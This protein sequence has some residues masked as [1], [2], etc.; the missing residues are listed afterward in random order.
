MWFGVW[1]IDCYYLEFFSVVFQY[2]GYGIRVLLTWFPIYLL[3]Y[4]QYFLVRKETVL[5]YRPNL[6]V[7][8]CFLESYIICVILLHLSD[9]D[10]KKFVPWLPRLS[11]LLPMLNSSLSNH[12]LQLHPWAIIASTSF[13]A[14]SLNSFVISMLSDSNIMQKS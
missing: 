14:T 10:C 12:S 5:Y 1:Y 11:R 6:W 8:L 3:M 9:F 4:F 13:S 2:I 7:S